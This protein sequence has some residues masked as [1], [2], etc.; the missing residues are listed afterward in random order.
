MKKIILLYIVGSLTL[1]AQNLESLKR[2]IV[3][4]VKITDFTDE[5]GLRYK[6]PNGTALI[7][8][9]EKNY[10]GRIFLVTAKHVIE[11]DSVTQ[12]MINFCKK[13]D[14]NK[15]VVS[16]VIKYNIFKNEWRF[17]QTDRINRLGRDTTFYTYDIA[18]AEL[19]MQRIKID[20]E[21]LWHQP[22]DLNNFIT[23]SSGKNDTLKI[24]AFPFVNK[25]NWERGLTMGDLEEDMGLKRLSQHEAIPFEKNKF[26]YDLGEVLI[27]NPKFRPGYSGG[28]VF[29]SNS[30]S[31]KFA[32][33]SMGMTNVVKRNG[34]NYCFGFYIK[35]ENLTEAFRQNF[36]IH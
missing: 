9:D 25:F 26:V 27:E 5:K 30:Q 18:I 22:L 16:S 11:K 3:P 2:G 20:G 15:S 33:V 1:F 12:C 36:K 7:V 8:T 34:K 31:Y 17:H 35:A 23:S 29:Y 10:P 24:L 6:I 14:R 13:S 19:F 28:L 21:E 32:G 4:I